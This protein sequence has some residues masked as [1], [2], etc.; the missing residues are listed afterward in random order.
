[1]SNPTQRAI[2]MLRQHRKAMEAGLANQGSP[3]YDPN[4]DRSFKQDLDAHR[5]H[6]A[7]LYLD[8]YPD[9][10][11]Q[12]IDLGWVKRT[13]T[14]KMSG[15]RLNDLLWLKFSRKGWAVYA[16]PPET[17]DPDLADGFVVAWVATRGEV[18]RWMKTLGLPFKK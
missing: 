1:M 16:I 13:L 4:A 6:L 8:E 12:L 11:A 10:Y 9:D 14:I 3:Y 15:A 17:D 7:Y 5:E 2:L 18:Y